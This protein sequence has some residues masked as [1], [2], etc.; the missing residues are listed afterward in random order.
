[1][2][3]ESFDYL[4]TRGDLPRAR[5]IATR[6]GI[7][8]KVTFP[9]TPVAA[10]LPGSGAPRRGLPAVLGPE[11]LRNTLRLW[12]AF[13]LITIGFQVASSWTPKLLEDAGMS[14]QQS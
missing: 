2:I 12:G 7:R 1:F 10:D 3:P 11:F 6:L 9:S 8:E 13:A 14:A 5:Q 4:R